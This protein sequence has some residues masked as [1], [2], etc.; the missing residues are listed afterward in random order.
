MVAICTPTNT[1][2]DL[3]EKYAR[4]GK[5]I[6]CEKPIDLDLNRVKSCL[7]VVAE[8]K[9]QLMVGFNRRFDPHFKAVRDA[10]HMKKVGE[11][12]Q[13]IISSRDPGLPP[14]DYISVSGG[15]FRDMMIHDFDMARFLL[16]EEIE[17]VYAIGS[18][19]VDEEVAARGDID[20]AMAVLTT[21]NG[22]QAHINCSRRAIYGYDQRVEVHGSKGM[23]QAHNPIPTM[24][25][26]ANGEG[27]TSQPLHDFFMTRYTEAYAAEIAALIAAVN[28]GAP[29]TPNGEDG[30]IALALAEAANLSMKEKRAIKVSEV[31]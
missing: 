7:N 4:A 23:V 9:A 6:F 17:S 18:V 21:A 27:Y 12:E 28:D 26:V 11:V 29:L 20:T 1:H 15:L 8:T 19:L 16:D 10:I 3:I 13:V 2:A 25:E 22:K 5:V 31:L 14:M 24:I 30:M